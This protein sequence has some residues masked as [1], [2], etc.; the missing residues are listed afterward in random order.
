MHRRDSV[1]RAWPRRPARLGA[2]VPR[3]IGKAAPVTDDDG[4]WRS[5][6]RPLW[7]WRWRRLN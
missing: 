4:G 3:L 7:P 5:R 1:G 2:Q 6:C